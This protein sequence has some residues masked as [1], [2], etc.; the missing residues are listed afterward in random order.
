MKQHTTTP[1]QLAEYLRA[2]WTKAIDNPDATEE[3]KLEGSIK[4]SLLIYLE[5]YGPD[6]LLDFAKDYNARLI[7]LDEHP[8]TPH[9]IRRTL[10]R[11][12]VTTEVVIAH[13]RNFN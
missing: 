10:S 13:L 5:D 7:A 2:G 9:S 3:Q 12:I 11:Q 4:G 8:A 6:A 1:D